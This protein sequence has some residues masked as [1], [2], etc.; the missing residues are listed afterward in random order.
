[1]EKDK[2]GKSKLKIDPVWAPVV[3]KI[4]DLSYRG[5]GAQRICQILLQEGIK[6]KNGRPFTKN[7][8]L[9]ILE[10]EKYMGATAFNK[11]DKK[12]HK[13]FKPKEEW[14]IVE[15]A[16]EPI[17]SKEIFEA[18]QREKA[19]RYTNS[20]NGS[21]MSSWAFTGLLKCG[22]CGA[23]MVIE[24]SKS[25][26]GK[27][28]YYHNCQNYKHIGKEVCKGRRVR[29]DKL[30]D[31]LIDVICK[32]LFSEKNIADMIKIMNNMLENRQKTVLEKNKKIKRKIRDI[33]RRLQVLYDAIEG[34]YVDLED[35][36]D[37][38]RQLK[39]TKEELIKQLQESPQGSEFKRVEVTPSFNSK[40]YV[41]DK[42]LL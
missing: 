1:V 32:N 19:K 10:N 39:K 25:S 27:V 17:V 12:N 20:D 21:P 8:I 33:E 14:I 35:I 34:G 40:I 26:T 37:R 28:Y 36:G 15:N 2:N 29:A 23:S 38:I 42:A 5:V 24:P 3:K 18:V 22:E 11:R 4:F 7:T 30:D 13:K 31:F 16:Y 9:G 6:N 41:F